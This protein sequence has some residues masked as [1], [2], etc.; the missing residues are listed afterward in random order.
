MDGNV[1]AF[2]I[3]VSVAAGLGAGVAPAKHAAHDDVNSVL[4]SGGRGGGSGRLNRIRA[5]L[6]GV[7]AAASVVLVVL[8]ALLTRGMVAATR[9]D[10]GFAA[11]RMLAV[12]PAFPPGEHGRVAARAFVNAAAERLAAIPGIASYSLAS[13]PPYGGATRVTIFNR[14][15]GR[16]TINYNDTD[17]EYFSTLGLRVLRGRTY[18]VPE[19]RDRAPVAVVS[20]ALAR[21]FFPGEDPLG[22]PLSR[23]VEDGGD[24]VIIGVVSNAITTRLRERSEAAIYQPI[25]SPH[26]ARLLIRTQAS[27]SL[28]IATIR[29]ALQPLDSRA[30]LE[31]TPVSDGLARQLG[32]SRTLASL[33]STFA[34]V[35][36]CL[37]IVGLYG[38]TAFVINQRSQEITLRVA[39]GATRRD[40]LRMLLGDSLR[41]VMLGLGAGIFVAL[42]A[43]RLVSGTL[44]G[45]GPA[46]PIAFGVSIVIL[47]LSTIAAII[48]PARRAATVDP[49]E[50]L[51]QV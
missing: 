41:P 51:K 40:V 15:D 20:E 16:Y 17:A 10:V 34:A 5:T 50:V 7:Q 38:V 6:L 19:V 45:I 39:L 14:A 3:V 11:D 29:S 4:K 44:Y 43:G 23:V 32:E 46:D 49:A 47:L 24:A 13:F 30:R 26:A 37:A 42:G 25:A 1:L 18:T 31:V 8:A 36:L 48:V 33:A 35:A 12:V 22:Q 21:D 9:V 28:Y 27:S 2:L